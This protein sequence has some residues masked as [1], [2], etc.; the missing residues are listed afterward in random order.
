MG[1]RSEGRKFWRPEERRCGGNWQYE[2]ENLL[3]GVSVFLGRCYQGRIWTMRTWTNRCTLNPNSKL[4][5]KL[6]PQSRFWGNSTRTRETPNPRGFWRS[7]ICHCY[8]KGNSGVTPL[9]PRRHKGSYDTKCRIV[10]L[11]RRNIVYRTQFF[12]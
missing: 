7:R 2:S 3:F 6:L 10:T 4:L 9:K 11:F 8:P 12:A 5:S 1:T